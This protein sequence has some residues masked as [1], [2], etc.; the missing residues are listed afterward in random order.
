MVNLGQEA[1]EGEQFVGEVGRACNWPLTV[2]A[3]LFSTTTKATTKAVQ[4][5][6][7]TRLFTYTKGGGQGPAYLCFDGAWEL[8]S[9]H[10]CQQLLRDVPS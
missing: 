8:G 1:S 2:E 9:Q 10:S 4:S 5:R 3:S 6:K 7:T